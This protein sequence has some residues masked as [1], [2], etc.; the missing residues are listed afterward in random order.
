M[1]SSLSS[2][3]WGQDNLQE[4]DVT[5]PPTTVHT[6]RDHSPAGEDWVLVGGGPAP[7][8][9]DLEGGL[10][11][12]SAESSPSISS[13]SSDVGDGEPMEPSETCSPNNMTTVHPTTLAQRAAKKQFQ[14][15]KS[16][17]IIKQ[18]NYGKNNSSKALNRNNKALF[19]CGSK[20]Q[21][22]RQNFNIKMAG[23]NKNIKQC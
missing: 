11:L 23:S 7:A 2:Y 9:G 6:H 8:P 10:P 18:K 5:G 22:T 16:A 14:S 1:L 3:I 19:V 15:V 13:C 4:Q 12:P 17:Q 21:V 20:K